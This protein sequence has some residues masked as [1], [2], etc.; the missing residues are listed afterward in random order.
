VELLQVLEQCC[1]QLGVQPDPAVVITDFKSAAH[2]CFFHLT[3]ATW[4]QIRSEGL[5]NLYK[6][7]VDF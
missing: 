7:N 3:Q 1:T 5:S 4:R 2:G 6:T